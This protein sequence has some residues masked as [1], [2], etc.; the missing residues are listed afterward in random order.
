MSKTKKKTTKL[1]KIKKTIKKAKPKKKTAKKEEDKKIEIAK[2][3]EKKK[4]EKKEIRKET[5]KNYIYA[6]GGRKTS[7]AQVRIHPKGTGKIII[8]KKSL[9]EYFPYFEFQRIVLQP[10]KMVNE[11]NKL[12]ISV[13]VKGGG[14]RGQA[15]AVRHGI[16]RALIKYNPEYRVTLKKAGFLTRD[17]RIK[18]RKKPGLK[19]A[20]R[21]PQWQKR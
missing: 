21:A 18:E 16:A 8:N 19:R 2:K 10:L 17:A 14:V 20:R 11:R 7:T 15:E 4:E 1:V 5:K 6:K 9:K 12:D 13:L 3:T